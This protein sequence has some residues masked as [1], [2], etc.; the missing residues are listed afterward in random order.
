MTTLIS[1]QTQRRKNGSST[2]FDARHESA[3]GMPEIHQRSLQDIIGQLPVMTDLDGG[4]P[5]LDRI[6]LLITAAGFEDRATAICAVAST[7]EID[8]HVVITYPTNRQ[9]N[10]SSREKLIGIPRSEQLHEVAYDRAEFRT[11]LLSIFEGYAARPGINVVVDVSGLSSYTFFRLMPVCLETLPA[12]RLHIFYAEAEEYF[13]EQK[14]W[15]EFLLSIA[16]PSD[17][18]MIARRYAERP[19]GF[20]S[21]GVEIVFES[22]AFLGSNQDA[23]PVQIVAFPNF[24]LERMKSMVSFCENQFNSLGR[25]TEWFLGQP[26]DVVKNGWRAEALRKLYLVGEDRL[27]SVSTLQY[28]D[29]LRALDDLWESKCTERHMIITTLGSKMQHF[30]VLCFLKMHQDVGLV[31]SEP[32]EFVAG[33]FST[34]I[35]RRWWIDCGCASDLVKLLESRGE[36]TFRW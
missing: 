7:L 25:D 17:S 16:D 26:P 19:A 21:R 13:P 22:E 18:L 12:A 34:G 6:H 31:L 28:R 24:S 5:P 4:K 3:H 35:G 8:N 14:E 30:G 10:E 9:D 1:R 15:T 27:H 23:L 11:R 29:T 2:Y 32:A 20:Q 33:R 36:L